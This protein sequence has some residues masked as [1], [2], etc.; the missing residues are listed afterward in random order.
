MPTDRKVIE[1]VGNK[2]SG[3][4]PIY[5]HQISHPLEVSYLRRRGLVIGGA[6]AL[7]IVAMIILADPRELAETMA[8]A[9]Y[10]LIGLVV[11]LYIGNVFLKSGRWSLLLRA[12]GRKIRFRHVLAYFCIGQAFN[13]AVPGRVVGEA[14]RV[15]AL[16]SQENV[17]AGAGLATIVTERVMDLVLITVMATTGLMLLFPELVDEVR[18]ALVLGVGSAVAINAAIIYFLARPSNI[19]RAGLWLAGV[20]RSLVRGSI[21][22]K[23][24]R[25]IVC[26]TG[27]FNQTIKISGQRNQHLL[28][29]AAGFTVIIWINE[30]LRLFLIMMSLGASPSLLSV[31]IAA[32]LATL[33]AVVLA[34]GSGNVLVISTVFTAS[35]IGFS[36]ATTAGV[37]SAM[38]SIWL[39]IPI[40]VAAMVITGFKRK[41]AMEEREGEE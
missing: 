27:S 26:S 23:M 35:G 20:V 31:M 22:E 2:G 36:T 7:L 21:G 10:A 15:Y 18:W 28:V 8:G 29:M 37:L 24:A 40:G 38:T 13:N 9:D 33:S 1:V 32:S 11:L 16:H 12:A 30:M 3:R 6:S 14:S 19:E 41:K 17:N 5:R 25:A 4:T 39:S 34:A